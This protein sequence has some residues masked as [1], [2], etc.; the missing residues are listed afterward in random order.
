MRIRQLEI[1]SVHPFDSFQLDFGASEPALHILYGQNEAGKSTLRQL[2]LDLLYGGKIDDNFRARY[3]GRSRMAGLLESKAGPIFQIRRKKRGTK[4]LLTD[5]AGMELSEEILAPYLSGY[6]KD[7]FSLLFGFD[8]NR[9]RQGGESLLQS[10]GNAGVSLFEAGGGIQYLQGMLAR[11]S[12]RATSLVDPRFTKTSAKLM[13]KVLRAYTEAEN[14]VRTS[15]LR[16]EDWQQLSEEI[17]ALQKKLNLLSAEMV[18]KQGEHTKLARI[19]RVRRHVERYQELSAKLEGLAG[20]PVFAVD[21]ENEMKQVI[22]DYK[23]TSGELAKQ[24]ETYEIYKRELESILLD[25]RALQLETE[26]TRLGE[27][28]SQYVELGENEIPSAKQRMAG[29]LDEAFQILKEVA[30]GISM[31]DAEKLQ[32][33]YAVREEIL[34]LSDELKMAQVESM[35][36]ESR[37]QELLGDVKNLEFEL[38]Q[39]GIVADTTKLR[40][41]VREIREFGDLEERIHKSEQEIEKKTASMQMLLEGQQLWNGE[42][43]EFVKISVPLRETLDTYQES[44][45]KIQKQIED[46]ERD[47]V[48]NQVEQTSV[49]NQLE[50]LELGGHVPVEAELFEARNQRNTGWM[51]VKQAWLN[52]QEDPVRIREFCD[53]KLTL[54]EA[55][56]AAMTKVDNIADLL[57]NE[58]DRSAQRMHL[59][60]QREQLERMNGDL[61]QHLEEL[62]DQFK[63]VTENWQK[64]WL[65]SKLILKSPA[66]MKEWIL[67][68]YRPIVDGVEAIH[69]LRMECSEWTLQKDNYSTF[70][71]QLLVELGVLPKEQLPSLRQLVALCEQ[72]VAEADG[73]LQ[74]QE[75][76]RARLKTEN[77]K[78]MESEATNHTAKGNLTRLES[79]WEAIRAGYTTLPKN[80]DIAVRYIHKVHEMFQRLT[81]V[82]NLK[83]EIAAKEEI[84]HSFEAGVRKLIQDLGEDEQT[85][86][87]PLAFVRKA[88]ARLESAKD[89]FARKDEKQK[90]LLEIEAKLS[91]VRVEM[92]RLQAVIQVLQSEYKR[93]SIDELRIMIENSEAYRQILMQQKQ[94]EG[95]L[96]EAGDGNEISKLVSDVEEIDDFDELPPRMDGLKNEIKGLEQDAEETRKRLWERKQ[97]FDKLDG[98][99]AEAAAFAESA[100]SQLAE[101]DPLW[102]EYVRIELARR[103]LSRS[104]D[105][106]RRRNES[107]VLEL[108]SSYFAKLTLSHYTGLSIDFEDNEPFI[109]ANT[110][111]GEKRRVTEMSDGTRDQLFLALRLAFLKQHLESSEPLPLVMDDIL[112]HFDDRRTEA[113]LEILHQF[114]SQTQIIYFT[115]HQSVIDAVQRLSDSSRIRVHHLTHQ[116]V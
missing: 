9:L 22:A 76:L 39:I 35:G 114:A 28:L 33:P 88:Q 48:K 87:T 10:G 115:H 75:S 67:D 54:S 57:R 1:S 49:L 91:H 58:S 80:P 92:N 20:I 21:L 42:F 3:E 34:R 63:I 71:S 96:Q 116:L 73:K 97:A 18:K 50:A 29:R 5:E 24:A 107:A 64:E 7:Q 56:E 27:R 90:R 6:S 51:L 61:R 78:L 44:F 43:N 112:V 36:A 26:I 111:A 47:L 65:P 94:I 13:N 79:A 52:Q 12:D 77:Q 74:L 109:E 45:A 37:Y 53:G 15:S 113:T 82:E 55:F 101:L 11:L 99:R 72:L 106:F 104:I 38:S 30:P 83:R 14:A 98:S 59:L 25:E 86:S 2:M 66:E 105:E 89:E 95:H 8:H 62:K 70:A 17:L 68:F 32:I 4:L 84:C 93:S 110:D 85:F 16:G 23:T 108:S 69:N 31:D 46:C 81:E 102:N 100:E 103:L 60:L 19:M 40:Q 41:F